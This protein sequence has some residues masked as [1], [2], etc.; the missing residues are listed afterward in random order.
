[1]LWHRSHLNTETHVC[2]LKHAYTHTRQ[3]G[4]NMHIHVDMCTDADMH[5]TLTWA[6]VLTDTHHMDTHIDICV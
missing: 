5:A 1:M 2:R 6:Y 4:T 3:A